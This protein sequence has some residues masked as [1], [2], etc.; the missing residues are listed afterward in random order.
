MG[1]ALRRLVVAAGVAMTSA[2]RPERSHHSD[3]SFAEK[4]S[5]TSAGRGSTMRCWKARAMS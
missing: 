2:E 3:L 5:G 4:M 1:L